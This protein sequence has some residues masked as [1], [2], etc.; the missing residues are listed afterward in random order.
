MRE[1]KSGHIGPQLE[2]W[3]R[4]GGWGR[5]GLG[6]QGHIAKILGVIAE[7]FAESC[8]PLFVCHLGLEDRRH[9]RTRRWQLLLVHAS[10]NKPSEMVLSLLKY[11]FRSDKISEG[12]YN[13]GREDLMAFHVF[14]WTLR[15]KKRFSINNSFFF[16]CEDIII[17]FDTSC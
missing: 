1:K 8:L 11:L 10:P 7:A 14:R 2:I 6:W 3:A 13:R 17:Y 15:Y 9:P 16:Y 5:E 12:I 4:G